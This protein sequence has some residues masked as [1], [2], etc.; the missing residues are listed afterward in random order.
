MVIQ[1]IFRAL[2]EVLTKKTRKTQSYVYHKW[3]RKKG[4][5]PGVQGISAQY[6]KNILQTI[7]HNDYLDCQ[8]QALRKEEMALKRKV[9]RSS[10]YVKQEVLGRRWLKWLDKTYWNAEGTSMN[11]SQLFLGTLNSSIIRN[12]TDFLSDNHRPR[13][14]YASDWIG[15]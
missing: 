13:G 11:H 2:K 10:W 15:S 8:K 14:M 4:Y 6:L 5:N 12:Q 3:R 9:P 7:R 1:T